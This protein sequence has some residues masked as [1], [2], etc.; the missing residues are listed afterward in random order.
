VSGGAQKRLGFETGLEATLWHDQQ[1]HH[2]VAY[3]LRGQAELRL[4]GL[5]QS[6][7]WEALSGD[8]RCSTDPTFCRPGVDQDSNGVARPNPGV[9]HSPSYVQ[10]VATRASSFRSGRTH[11]C[12]VL[13]G[14]YWQ[15]SHDLTDGSSGNAVY[16]VPG[17][18]Y[19][20]EKRVLL[21]AS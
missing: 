19:R 11:A 20:I 21:A 15:Q 1:A 2:R 12:A 5:E 10:M 13:F 3:E 16:D 9:T 8:S 6:P 17:R 14:L 4:D 18:R 7:M